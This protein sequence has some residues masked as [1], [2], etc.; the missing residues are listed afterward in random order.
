M[1][2]TWRRMP[3]AQLMYYSLRRSYTC[4]DANW[5]GLTTRANFRIADET[6]NPRSCQVEACRVEVVTAPLTV[7]K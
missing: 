4:S 5:R 6:D 1:Y 2:L 3:S 7:I